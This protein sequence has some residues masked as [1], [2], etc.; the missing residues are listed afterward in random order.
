MRLN[1]I[2]NTIDF[3]S[4]TPAETDLPKPEQDIIIDIRN[5]KIVFIEKNLIIIRR[6]LDK[7]F[8]KHLKDLNKFRRQELLTT[9]S[10]SFTDYEEFT[11]MLA[12]LRDSHEIQIFLPEQTNLFDN[13][14]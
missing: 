12:S 6:S 5:D 9:R 11:K 13:Q 14:K 3:D 8:Q 10:Y 4:P 7:S 1:L 2:Q